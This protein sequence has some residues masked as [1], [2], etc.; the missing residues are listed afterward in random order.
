MH[1]LNPIDLAMQSNFAPD[2]W[3]T[4]II[5]DGDPDYGDILDL[6]EA[7]KE[8]TELRSN[9]EQ[10]YLMPMWNEHYHIEE[11]VA[12]GFSVEHA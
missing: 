12:L 7:L 3:S 5:G 6:N 8:L 4:V 1:K 10:A 2:G 9:G 11:L